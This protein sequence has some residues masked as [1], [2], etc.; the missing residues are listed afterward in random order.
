MTRV[1][2]THS[3]LMASVNSGSLYLSLLDGP[4]EIHKGLEL[5]TL[6]KSLEGGLKG[7]HW[8]GA[9]GS[10]QTPLLS[11]PCTKMLLN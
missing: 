5:R 8:K 2:K 1:G 11:S 7:S 9:L 4:L 6:G 3:P 10:P